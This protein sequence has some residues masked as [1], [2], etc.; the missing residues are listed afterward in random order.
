MTTIA[1]DV[2]RAFAAEWT[3]NFNDVGRVRSATARS[4]IEG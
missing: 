4:A 3:F 1:P 2:A